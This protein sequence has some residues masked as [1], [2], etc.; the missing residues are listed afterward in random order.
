VLYELI[1]KELPYLRRYAR[2]M[3]GDQVAGDLCVETMLQEHVLKPQPSDASLPQD[4]T[5]LF[6][7]LDKIVAAPDQAPHANQAI[8]ALQNLSSLS[9]RALFLTAVEQLDS[10]AVGK[11]L[12]V[13][14][15]ELADILSEAERDLASALATDVLIIEDEAMI[16]FQLKEIVESLGHNMVARATTRDEAV[17]QARATK[18]GLML[19]DIQLADGS[20]G[21][22]A[23]DDIFTFHKPPSIVITAFPER[24][25]SG[26]GNEPTFL[27]PKPFRADHVKTVISQALL[28]KATN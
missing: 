1:T 25:L 12:N 13:D 24:L 3:T 28:T 15:D 2:A 18:P 20:S 27:I 21:L 7:L 16:A 4:R 23:M 9:R 6:A 8:P 26:R 10:N 14:A 22:D 5:D 19:V 17:N 11:I